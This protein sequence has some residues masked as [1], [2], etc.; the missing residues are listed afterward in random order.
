MRNSGEGEL[1]GVEFTFDRQLNFLP[2]FLNGLGFN[3][4]VAWFESE[5]TLVTDLR[6]GEKVPLFKQPDMTANV[7]LYYDKHGL[8][9]RLSYNYRGEYLNSIT[10]GRGTLQEHEI[11]GIPADS[12]DQYVEGT[13]RLDFTMRYKITPSLQVF[14]E[15]INLTNEPVTRVIKHE[16]LPVFKQYTERVFTVGVKWNL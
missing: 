5:A 12:R 4:N 13:G 7:S 2:S 6:V 1:M 3:S 9:A 16:S 11:L 15:A 14:V 10:A 8:F